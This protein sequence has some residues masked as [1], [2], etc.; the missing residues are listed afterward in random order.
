M[1]LLIGVILFI[2]IIAFPFALLYG[3]L[4]GRFSAKT[5]LMAGK[6]FREIRDHCRAV[7]HGSGGKTYRPFPV[8]SAEH[9]YVIHYWGLAAFKGRRPGN[10][11]ITNLSF[12]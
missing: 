3:R 12:Y 7:S 4:A 5:M 6:Y 1:T 11:N 2:Q 8:G 9:P 10:L